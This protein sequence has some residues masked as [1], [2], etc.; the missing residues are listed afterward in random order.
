MT[1]PKTKGSP[2]PYCRDDFEELLVAHI[3]K[4]RAFAR[5]FVSDSAAADDLVQETM[6]KAWKAQKSFDPGTNMRAWLFTILRNNFLNDVRRKKREVED[7]DEKLANAIRTGPRQLAAIELNDL[8]EILKDLPHDQRE[9]LIL[10]SVEGLSYK[11][12]AEISQCAIGTVKSRVGRAR[13]RLSE[14]F[15]V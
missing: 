15:E 1:K 8:N 7:I 10:V 11:E 6:I 5:S 3:P 4:L 12:V 9:A 13:Q 14:L 2:L